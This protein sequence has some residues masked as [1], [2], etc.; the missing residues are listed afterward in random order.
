MLI[1]GWGPS[2]VTSRN[3]SKY[4]VMFT[5]DK[6]FHGSIFFLLKLRLLQL[7]LSSN[8]RALSIHAALKALAQSIRNSTMPKL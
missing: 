6:G 4:Y 5:D 7:L 1:S 2:P 3:G 8:Y